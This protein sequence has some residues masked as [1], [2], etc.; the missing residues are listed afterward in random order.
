LHV[1]SIDGQYESVKLLL[2]HGANVHLRNRYGRTP[3]LDSILF[4]HSQVAQLLRQTGA[5]FS[6]NE[7]EEVIHY[8]CKAVIGND[9][10][11]VNLFLQCGANPNLSLYDGRTP[12]HLVIKVYIG[13][14]KE[15]YRDGLC[16][17][18]R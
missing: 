8:L 5:H 1:A 3:L 7:E 15:F 4:K 2:K 6:P 11:M 17:F 14:F 13:C 16:T 12:L 10:E 18:G 9:V